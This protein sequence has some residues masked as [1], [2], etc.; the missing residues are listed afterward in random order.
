MILLEGE[1]EKVIIYLFSNILDDWW[2]EMTLYNLKAESWIYLCLI[3]KEVLTYLLGYCQGILC[4]VPFLVMET[5]AK[6][7]Q[8]MADG[9]SRT[10]T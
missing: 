6:H 9:N 8:N 1:S 7:V 10:S 3:S 5:L 4:R 2:G